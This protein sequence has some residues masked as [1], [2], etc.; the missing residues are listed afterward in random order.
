RPS[1]RL[2]VAISLVVLLA[3]TAVLL[4]GLDVRVKAALSAIATVYGGDALR[5]FLRTRWRRCAW[6][7]A[8]HWR[9]YDAHGVEAVA[10]LQRGFVRGNWIVLN[11]IVRGKPLGF[12]LAPDNTDAD[13]LRRLRIRL[14][15]VRS[16]E[17]IDA[18]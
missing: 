10:Q 15:R 2:A 3:L 12:V 4:S 1:R 7:P 17:P 13:V 14:A 8:G 9:L 16:V 11:L 18:A 6:H 5:H